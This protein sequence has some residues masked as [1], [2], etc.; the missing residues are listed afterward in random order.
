MKIS[1]FDTIVNIIYVDLV[2]YVF[3]EDAYYCN[4]IINEKFIDIKPTEKYN[5]VM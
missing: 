4:V 3:I 2:G 5:V 1:L